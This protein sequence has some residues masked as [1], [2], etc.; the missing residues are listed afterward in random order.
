MAL[1]KAFLVRPGKDVTRSLNLNVNLKGRYSYDLPCCLREQSN[2]ISASVHFG[3]ASVVVFGFDFLGGQCQ[4]QWRVDLLTTEGVT[5]PF[6]VLIIGTF[7]G[8]RGS[9]WEES[10]HFPALISLRMSGWGFRTSKYVCLLRVA[11]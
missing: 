3:G 2:L 11:S 10:S 5:L 6:Q 4:F 9:T 1:I 7:N 8:V